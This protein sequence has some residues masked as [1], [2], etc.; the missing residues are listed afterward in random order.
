MNKISEFM[1]SRFLN[2]V[3]LIILIF[4]AAKSIYELEQAVYMLT[5]I[6][7]MG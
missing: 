6:V 5:L 7:A 1:R 4:A 2:N 3:L